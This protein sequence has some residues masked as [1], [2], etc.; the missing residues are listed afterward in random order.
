MSRFLSW[1]LGVKSLPE[2]DIRE[3]DIDFLFLPDRH[4]GI[5]IAAFLV[6]AAGFAF[7]IYLKRKE[8]LG[9]QRWVL[10]GTRT[11]AILVF[12][13]L[14]LGP[15]LRVVARNTQRTTVVFLADNSKSM[16]IAD[17]RVSE[18]ALGRTAKALGLLKGEGKPLDPGTRGKAASAKRVDIMRAVLG[19]AEKG[20]MREFDEFA[21]RTYSFGS[22][23][24]EGPEE[25]SEPLFDWIG[26]LKTEETE[27][28]LGTA[29]DV[30]LR[31]LKGKPVAGVVV[32]SDFSYNGGADPSTVLEQAAA[33]G[34]PAYFVGIGEPDAKDLQVSFLAMRDVL[35]LDDPAPVTVKLRHWGYAGREVNLVVSDDEGE[36]ER[37]TV[38]LGESGEQT[39]TI[40]ITPEKAG[41]ATFTVRAELFGDELSTDNNEKAKDVRVID[42]KIRVLWVETYPRWEYRYAKNLIMRDEKRFEAKVLL[43]ESDPEVRDDEGLYLEKFPA[44]EEDLFKYHLVVVGDIEATRMSEDEIELLKRYV[45][46]EGG[47]LVFLAGTRFGPEQWI[48]T[49]LHEVL[50]VVVRSPQDRRTPAD[51]LTDPVTQPTRAKLTE[52][53]RRHP[54]LFVSDDEDEQ[55]KAWE[56]YLL[57]Y[58]RVGIEKEKPGALRLLE[59]A[60]ED[61]EPL[62][63]YSR[64]GSGVVVYMGTEELWR[65]RYRPGPVTH[66]RYWG[67]LLQQTALARLLGESRRL[68]L[69]LSKKDVSVGE[70]QIVSARVLGENYL[71]LQDESVTVT[72]ELAQEDG[73]T[74]SAEV[75]LNVVSKEGGLYEGKYTPEGVGR[76]TVTLEQGEEKVSAVFRAA[77]PQLEYENPALDRDRMVEWAKI[78]G[79]NV[80]HP[81]DVEELPVE[82]AA[83]AKA[84]VIRTEDD[85]WDA[86]LWAF[87]FILCAGAEWFLRKRNNL[88]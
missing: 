13:L 39:E 52:R 6:A 47:T 10:M 57:I 65:W 48:E 26:G 37:K 72:V 82:L 84:A 15:V 68:A 55:R 21:V 71:P 50:P 63:V 67:A 76:H 43:Y 30:A 20:L 7:W 69:F 18:E 64:Y 86:P 32:L 8:L 9:R 77:E 29:L 79:G 16:A 3:L 75:V 22:V 17:R 11:I 49:P 44:K 40:K 38:T 42:E 73:T 51:E 41:K 27:T 74:K 81:W 53:G 4:A 46:D 24:R 28:R 60:E 5:V 23:V 70:E 66:D 59:T 35:F 36:V 85:L 56:E 2:G 19:N 58:R 54:L 62:I 34:I 88:A 1:L 78:A 33:R 83:K 25:V 14:L 31:D 80:Y 87:L 12:L 61:P 45:S